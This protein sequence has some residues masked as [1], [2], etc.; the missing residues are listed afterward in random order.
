MKINETESKQT[1]KRTLCA[2]FGAVLVSLAMM[3]LYRPPIAPAQTH[4]EEVAT[5]GALAMSFDLAQTMHV[6]QKLENGCLQKV[7]VKD[8][9]NKKQIAL[10][11]SHLQ[12]EAEKFGKVDFSDQAKI[13]GES[14]PGL[15]ELKAGAGKID[16]RYAPLPDGAQIR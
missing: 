9:S 2:T 11:Q 3:A 1:R 15:A 8:P 4:Q 7:V 14:M 12:K 10:I 13:H 5:R 16:V 6:F